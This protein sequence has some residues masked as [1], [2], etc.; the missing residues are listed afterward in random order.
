MNKRYYT[1]KACKNGHVSERL[2]SNRECCECARVR[3]NLNKHQKALRN[4]K[5]A[6]ANKD[7]RNQRARESNAKNREK[8][9]AYLIAWRLSNLERQ[10]ELE[11]ARGAKS[12]KKRAEYAR[13]RWLKNPEAIKTAS[14]K[15][16]LKNKHKVAARTSKRK[17]NR[18]L[19]TPKWAD[20]GAIEIFYSE[21]RKITEATGV[22]H[23]VDHI[24][25]LQGEN[26]RGLHVS[27]N[28][29]ILTASENSRK[30]NHMIS[31]AS[32]PD[33]LP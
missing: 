31:A 14:K 7:L 28:L 27:W 29:Q 22:K 24:V 15:W 4:K 2:K 8:R 19:A 10:K 30:K 11:R 32:P 17:A 33:A 16:R 20:L 3:D 5:Y 13:D 25:P 1:G 6:I 26:V 23:Q 9:R 18:L 12:S 21:A